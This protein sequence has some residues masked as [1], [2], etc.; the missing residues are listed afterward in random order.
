MFLWVNLEENINLSPEKNI[1][2]HN[3]KTSKQSR[4]C[5]SFYSLTQ[6]PTPC[7]KSTTTVLSSNTPNTATVTTSSTNSY[8]H[9]ISSLN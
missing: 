1:H 9:L 7:G 5:N 4:T 2:I 6:E 3:G 8:Y